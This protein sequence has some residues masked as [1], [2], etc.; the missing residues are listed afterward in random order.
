VRDVVD[1]GHAD[2][3]KGATPATAAPKVV[4][5]HVDIKIAFVWAFKNIAE[6]FWVA[7]TVLKSCSSR[8]CGYEKCLSKDYMRR[9]L[10]LTVG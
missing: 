2:K 7:G 6:R 9:R 10:R 4:V 3:P 1:E 5:A 8:K